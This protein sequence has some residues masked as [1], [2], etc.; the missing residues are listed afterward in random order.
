[1][2]AAWL[3]K[4]ITPPLAPVVAKLRLEA[5]VVAP[6][7][8]KVRSALPVPLPNKVMVAAPA[9]GVRAPSVSVVFALAKPRNSRVPP[10]VWVVV[11]AEKTIVL[12]PAEPMTSEAAAVAR[13][14][15]VPL[16]MVVPPR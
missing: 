1:M 10:A 13:S 5:A 16:W 7:D 9:V 12:V 2:V 14:L 11:S 8:V 3:V 4:V 6:K 15:S